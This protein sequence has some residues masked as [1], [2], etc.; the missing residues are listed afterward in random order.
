MDIDKVLKIILILAGT[1]FLIVY[2][3]VPKTHC[4]SCKIEY[5]GRI[6]NGHEAFRI[7]EDGCISYEKP[8]N[9]NVINLIENFTYEE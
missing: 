3:Q 8:W 7:F 5:D 9:N 6:I 4:E 2:T 1:F